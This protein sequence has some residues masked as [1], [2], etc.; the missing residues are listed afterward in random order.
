MLSTIDTAGHDKLQY[1]FHF[2]QSGGSQL[3]DAWLT[4]R[5]Y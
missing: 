3:L 4:E 1:I 2:L 5:N